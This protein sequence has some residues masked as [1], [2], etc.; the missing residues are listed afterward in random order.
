M[1]YIYIYIYASS[2]IVRQS[3]ML[4]V[5]GLFDPVDD[6]STSGGSSGRWSLI[7]III[8]CVVGG[9]VV[10]G[11]FVFAC[12][13]GRRVFKHKHTGKMTLR[14]TEKNGTLSLPRST[15]YH[16]PAYSRHSGSQVT[17]INGKKRYVGE[18]P[19]PSCTGSMKFVL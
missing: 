3:T 16:N 11:T 2:D 17:T 13:A 8:L 10:I 1:K 12:L 14:D 15:H 9:V 7:L 6:E 19:V 4:H 18:W 5:L